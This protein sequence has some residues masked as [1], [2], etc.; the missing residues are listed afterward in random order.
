[1]NVDTIDSNPGP[2]HPATLEETTEGADVTADQP[3]RSAG[4]APARRR[5]DVPGL[6]A[7]IIVGVVLAPALIVLLIGLIPSMNAIW[8]L[9][10]VL[11]PILG[12][13]G[14]IAIVL[15]VVGLVARRGTARVLS[16]L[17]IVLGLVALLPIAWLF[18]GAGS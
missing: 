5:L 7:V 17:G 8:W 14:A 11:I 10:I 18:T 3:Y 16:I 13:A 9:G 12:V 15:G 1:V 4:A 6:I 2:R